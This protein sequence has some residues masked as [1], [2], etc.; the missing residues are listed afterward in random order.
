MN[1]TLELV[2]VNCPEIAKLHIEK[3]I[4]MVHLV[5]ITAIVNLFLN[6]FLMLTA[7]LGN[8]IIIFAIL[9]SPQLQTPSYL[10]ITS[11]AFTDL[12]VGLTFHPLQIVLNVDYLQSNIERMCEMANL[13]TLVIVYFGF[14]SMFMVTAISID[15]YLA[16]TL[17]NR[18]SIIVT[19]K[20]VRVLIVASWILPSLLSFLTAIKQFAAT[21]LVIDTSLSVVFLSI[22]FVFY[23]KSFRA[24]HLYTAQVHAQQPNPSNGSFSVVRYKNILRTMFLV[25]GCLV[26]CSLPLVG[27][28]IARSTNESTN[29]TV[30]AYFVSLT[31]VSLNSSINPIIY[32]IRFTDIRTKCI[33]LIWN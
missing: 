14:L 1:V 8:G 24:L 12:L 26:L 5:E 25:L 2:K 19:K 21:L 15:R 10:L 31:V 13:L 22:T 20:R 23:G 27:T 32:L 18:Y 33:Q 3:L 30:F 6:A 7:T 28:L 9:R 29:E 4:A 11:S 17:R 16:L